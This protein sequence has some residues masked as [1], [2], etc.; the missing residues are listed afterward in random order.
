MFFGATRRCKLSAAVDRNRIVLIGIALIF[1]NLV[2]VGIVAGAVG[3]LPGTGTV[4]LNG[5]AKDIRSQ[6]QRLMEQREDNLKVLQ[7]IQATLLIPDS[8]RR[9]ESIVSLASK[10]IDRATKSV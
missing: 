10:L 9:N 3:L 2:A 1:L 8:A 7:A 6:V 5:L 4:I